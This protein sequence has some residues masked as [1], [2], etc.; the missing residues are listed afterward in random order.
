MFHL[1]L[2]Q[3]ET[4]QLSP[5]VQAFIIKSWQAPKQDEQLQTPVFTGR[6]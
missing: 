6:S 2:L 4:E 1:Y 5:Y 3:P